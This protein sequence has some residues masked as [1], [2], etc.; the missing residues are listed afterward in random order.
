MKITIGIL[1]AVLTML[2]PAAAQRNEQHGGH[3]V[4]GGRQNIPAHGPPARGQ[5]PR[6]QEARPQEARPQEPARPQEH[7]QEKFA[8]RGGHPEAPHVHAN[9]EWVGHDRPGVNYHLDRPFE[10]GR[11]T[12]GF[13]RGHVWH[14][15]GGGPDR[16]W[17]NGFYFGVGAMD[18][19]FVSD[20][21]WN[22]DDVV[23]YDDPDD[24]GW[25]L[26]YNV[27]LGTYV[28]VQFMGRQ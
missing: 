15:R 8:D 28:H 17:F 26:A 3:E 21:N 2:T 20:W 12:G 5:A 27:R 4:G 24:P 9:G 16:F 11:F 23:I 13:G 19:A 22:S 25:Y 10:H 1:A 14:L 18:L 6:P 7:P